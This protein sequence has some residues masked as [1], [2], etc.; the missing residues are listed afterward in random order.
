MKGSSVAWRFPLALQIVM[1][2]TVMSFIFTLP[3]SPRW[4]LKHD[5]VDEAR[6][7]LMI[8]EDL[9]P[10]SK[11]KINRDIADIQKSLAIAGRG[12][13]LDLLKMGDQRIFHRTVLAS[14]CQIFQ[15]MCGVNLI[16]CT[17]VLSSKIG[18]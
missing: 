1:S 2:L 10:E 16:T 5:R 6:E 15:Q 4:L 7:I 8:L 11:D 9:G 18:T 3:E 13:A 14:L 17:Y 12:S